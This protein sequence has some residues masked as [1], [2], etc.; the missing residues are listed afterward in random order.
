MTNDKISCTFDKKSISNR[1][2]QTRGSAAP[3]TQATQ[4]MVPPIP[5]SRR[6]LTATRSLVSHGLQWGSRLWVRLGISWH[7]HYSRDCNRKCSILTMWVPWRSSKYIYKKSFWQSKD[8]YVNNSFPGAFWVG[9]TGTL[10]LYY[11][12][13]QNS[14]T[15]ESLNF[16]HFIRRSYSNLI[17]RSKNEKIKSV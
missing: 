15:P 1:V 12:L 11:T 2:F 8:I 9:M 17:W 4:S 10:I 5:F 6:Q 16:P 14:N 3:R 7:F 13:F